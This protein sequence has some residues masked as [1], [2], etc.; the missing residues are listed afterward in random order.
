MITVLIVEIN[1]SAQGQNELRTIVKNAN[2]CTKERKKK[3]NLHTGN[4][5]QHLRLSLL[6]LA[7]MTMP[8]INLADIYLSKP[9][10]SAYCVSLLSKYGLF[11]QLH[12]S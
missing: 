1:V 11:S 8:K 9:C 2:K 7:L 12:W 3:R 6:P 4:P 10:A 5:H